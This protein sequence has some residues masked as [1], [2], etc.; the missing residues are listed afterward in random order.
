MIIRLIFMKKTISFLNLKI[1]FRQIEGI[2]KKL[3]GVF[4]LLNQIALNL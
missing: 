3:F 4:Q 2:S 1:F